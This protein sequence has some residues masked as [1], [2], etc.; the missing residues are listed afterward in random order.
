MTEEEKTEKAEEKQERETLS[1]G[2]LLKI[3]RGIEENLVKEHHLTSAEIMFIGTI[4]QASATTDYMIHNLIKKAQVQ[5]IKVPIGNVA[6][7]PGE[8]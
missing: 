5:V 7:K 3:A 2:E 4:L 1:I 6:F 8:N